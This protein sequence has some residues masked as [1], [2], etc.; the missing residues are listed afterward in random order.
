MA[1]GIQRTPFDTI[2]LGSQLLQS[3]VAAQETKDAKERMKLQEKQLGLQEK[4]LQLQAV[5]S[6][7]PMQSGI[8]DILGQL[9]GAGGPVQPRV[10][11]EERQFAGLQDYLEKNPDVKE[12]HNRLQA[13][14]TLLQPGEAVEGARIAAG[15]KLSGRDRAGMVSD[16]LQQLGS[17]ALPIWNA[18]IGRELGVRAH[19]GVKTLPERAVG[20]EEKRA[21]ETGATAEA[22]RIRARQDAVEFVAGGFQP[23]PGTEASKDPALAKQ[24]AE[25]LTNFAM[26]EQNTVS[27]DAITQMVPLSKWAAILKASAEP[28]PE[29]G[30]RLAVYKE[31]LDFANKQKGKVSKEMLEQIQTLGQSLYDEVLPPV[32]GGEPAVEGEG[33]FLSNAFSKLIGLAIGGP[34]EGN[35]TINGQPLKPELQNAIKSLNRAGRATSPLGAAREIG[36]AGL[37]ALDRAYQKV[38]PL[39]TKEPAKAPV[40][41]PTLGALSSPEASEIPSDTKS[42]LQGLVAAYRAA[43]A[44]DEE[45]SG[46]EAELLEVINSGDEKAQQ[47]YIDA[48]LEDIDELKKAKR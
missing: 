44:S 21:K 42:K 23:L 47:E 4:Q 19:T 45:A 6:A 39:I 40:I 8:A 43:G 30:R 24:Y 28:S 3:L 29:F 26:G 11:V 13:T 9:L 25:E 32:E 1:G 34:A 41:Q 27:P 22:A 17:P 38:L 5:Q 12:M 20:A 16:L 46:M 36:E 48:V 18:A 7:D 37:K 14:G 10:S 31:M 33:G 35:I 2:D 15:L